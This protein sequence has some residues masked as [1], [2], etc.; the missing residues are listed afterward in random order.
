[1]ITIIDEEH[2]T[3]QGKTWEEVLSYVRLKVKDEWL[4]ADQFR[5]YLKTKGL[6]FPGSA[7]N[8][9]RFCNSHNIEFQ[10]RGREF[11]YKKEA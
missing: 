2:K 5:E 4:N 9:T 8:R 3:I 7:Q 6:N 1:M 10:K 11:Y